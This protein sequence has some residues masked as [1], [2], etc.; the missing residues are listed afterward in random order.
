MF[1]NFFLLLISTQF[2][3]AMALTLNL[4][5]CKYLILFSVVHRTHLLFLTFFLSMESVWVFSKSSTLRACI[6][7]NTINSVACCDH[8][9]YYYCISY[10]FISFIAVVAAALFLD[11]FRFFVFF[12]RVRSF[13]GW[14]K[15][16]LKRNKT[17]V[18]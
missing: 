13:I 16:T 2:I 18:A 7:L 12:I 11:A 3:R 15:K 14:D 5:V 9:D 10:G 17:N 1:F 4:C 8:P 6:K